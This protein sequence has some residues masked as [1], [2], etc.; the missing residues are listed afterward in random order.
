MSAL[1]RIAVVVVL[2]CFA[3]CAAGLAQDTRAPGSGDT[4]LV[5]F[6][7]HLPGGEQQKNFDGAAKLS[8]GRILEMRGWCLDPKDK[9]L[10]EKGG[11][12]CTVAAKPIRQKIYA[13][14]DKG[15]VL[16]LQCPPDA[17][18]SVSTAAGDFSLKPAGLPAG[19]KSQF[20]NGLVTA[21]RGL[22]EL[23][24]AETPAD[25]DYPS[26]AAGKNG[27]LHVA[28]ISSDCKSD[29]ILYREFDGAKWSEPFELAGP[30]EYFDPQVGVDA[31]GRIRVVWTGMKNDVWDICERVRTKDKWGP[32]ARL[33]DDDAP[34]MLPSMTADAKGNLYLCRQSFRNG[35][36]DI[37]LKCFRDGRWGDDIQVSGDP[38]GDWY[39]AVAADGDGRVFVAWDSYRAGDYNI[40]MARVE[41][42]EVSP[43]RPV[44]D[45]LE[46]EAHPSL[47]CDGQGRVWIAWDVGTPN[48]GLDYSSWMGS[49]KAPPNSGPLHGARKFVVA[50][51]DGDG[52]HAAPEQVPQ[53][54]EIYQTEAV[55]YES[56]G[57]RRFY[58][59]PHL[60]LD[61]AGRL[62]CF[63]R[64]NR[65][66]YIGH[67]LGGARWQIYG[68]YLDGGRWSDPVL[69]GCSIGRNDQRLSSSVD[70]RGDIH[71]AWATGNYFRDINY[72]VCVGCMARAKSGQAPTPLG[73]RLD[74][75]PR[76]VRVEEPEPVRVTVGGKDYVLCY[77]DLHR[78]TEI[79]LCTPTIDG[80]VVDQYRYALDVAK[81]DFLAITD[82]TRDTR[83][84]PWWYS[85]KVV[86][87]LFLKDKFIT[88]Y[89]Y[90]RSNPGPTGGHRNVIFTTRGHEVYR[91][92]PD[93]WVLW[94]LLKGQEAITIP[95]TPTYDR[96]KQS[97]TWSYNNPH[98]EPLVE[99]FQ[100][101]RRSYEMPPWAAASK[102]YHPP[103]AKRKDM[104][105]VWHALEKGYKLGFI[106][107]SDHWSTHLSYACVYAPEKTRKAIFRGMQQRHTYGAM[108]KI[109]LQFSMDGHLMGE[110]YS[111][112][113]P[114]V[115]HVRISGTD[116]IKQV[117][118]VKNNTFIHTTAPGAPNVEF[119][120]LDNKIKA[121]TS[122]YYVRLVQEN[123]K[124]AWA[125][126]IWVTYRTGG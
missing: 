98:F 45:T 93:P 64:M 65:Q 119:S 33:T 40:Y 49:F 42:G 78:H 110:E 111:T 99:I 63:Y 15:I 1:R 70:E 54:T 115:M 61:G 47:A 26:I 101:Y 108:D 56:I 28:W 22:P 34:D 43:P 82:H 106:A 102:P 14:P 103:A 44:T 66:G 117:D 53:D 27:R 25:E 87:L 30:G 73:R 31:D 114:P 96:K 84:Y 90:E 23:K 67:P 21:S 83:P 9:I 16:K 20:L 60:V 86:D 80:S 38:A 92:G 89:A 3:W 18:L 35:N 124:M 68:V 94:K 91:A 55:K 123:G 126:P 6:V 74:P 72:D 8:S 85:Q 79:S 107:S 58:E 19:K 81:L 109:V 95:H 88:F 97:G 36:G 46:F 116:K 104:H 11:W 122:Y 50:C 125:S 24:L 29:R 105:T 17:V 112:D 37:F 51:L 2:S 5:L 113:K 118:I 59:R 100:A 76:K 121:G 39:P 4:C 120:F 10:P 12:K 71:L 75:R 48:W 57:I 77:G 7:F 52:L 62:W 69:L 32:V 41:N 13:E